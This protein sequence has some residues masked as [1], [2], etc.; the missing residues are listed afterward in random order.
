MLIILNWPK[1]LVNISVDWA[2]RNSRIY[3]E[4][5]GFELAVGLK[6]EK[7]SIRGCEIATN[8][9]KIEGKFMLSIP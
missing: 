8:S 3:K 4:M 5:L 2:E 9:G 7:L 6:G 1:C